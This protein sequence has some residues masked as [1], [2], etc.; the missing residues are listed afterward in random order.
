MSECST[1]W[2]CGPGVFQQPRCSQMPA[3]VLSTTTT[4]SSS[5][6]HTNVSRASHSGDTYTCRR[7]LKAESAKDT[8]NFWLQGRLCLV[9]SLTLSC[10]TRPS[11]VASRLTISSFTIISSSFSSSVHTSDAAS[12][13]IYRAPSVWNCPTVTSPLYVVDS[14]FVISVQLRVGAC[15]LSWLHT[16][17]P[18]GAGCQGL[19]WGNVPVRASFTTLLHWLISFSLGIHILFGLYAVVGA[20]SAIFYP[21]AMCCMSLTF[22]MW[23]G[24][25]VVFACYRKCQGQVSLINVCSELGSPSLVITL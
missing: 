2:I 3:L 25:I 7:S 14:T 19:P 10:C 12:Y 13:C 11:P 17:R 5:T 6:T 4:G 8:H 1:A 15:A 22:N 20:T 24:S 9:L 18:V 21:A 23:S 16:T